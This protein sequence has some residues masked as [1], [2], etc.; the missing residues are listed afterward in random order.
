[1]GHFCFIGGCIRLS[2]ISHLQSAVTIKLILLNCNLRKSE[3]KKFLNED[4]Q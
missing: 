4:V 1:M 2:T 3:K